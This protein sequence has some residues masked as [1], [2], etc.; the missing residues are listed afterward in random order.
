MQ[1]QPQVRII[2]NRKHLLDFPIIASCSTFWN[3][4]SEKYRN[5]N[6]ISL[7]ALLDLKLGGLMARCL[8][9]C[10][11]ISQFSLTSENYRIQLSKND[12][13]DAGI[14]KHAWIVVICLLQLLSHQCEYN[15][16][17]YTSQITPCSGCYSSYLHGCPSIDHT[18]RNILLWSHHKQSVIIW[19]IIYAHITY[20]P[21]ITSDKVCDHITHS[22][23]THSLL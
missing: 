2:P 16:S 13:F 10:I 3:D 4:I 20:K 22:Q 6:N 15:S 5:W 8:N 9:N 17:P 14:S 12:L 23:M 11:K 7:T 19:D 1:L 18:H 21:V